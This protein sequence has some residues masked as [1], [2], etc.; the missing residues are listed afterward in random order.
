MEISFSKI[1]RT[2]GS[3]L[4]FIYLNKVWIGAI[5]AHFSTVA[6]VA[7]LIEGEFDKDFY[8]T[9]REYACDLC[10]VI[11][12][13]DVIY[14]IYKVSEIEFGSNIVDHD[15]FPVT[16]KEFKELS[17]MIS[18]QHGAH[19]SARSKISEHAVRD[20]FSNNGYIVEMSTPDQDHKKIDLICYN[21][22][23][24]LPTQVKSGNISLQEIVGCLEAMRV[25][26]RVLDLSN[27]GR[28]I[29]YTFSAKTFPKK[30][31]IEKIHLENKFKCK[32][33]FILQEEI[34]EVEKKYKQSLKD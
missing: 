25:E 5:H 18:R 32:I 30:M 3:D 14:T 2:S 9:V 34:V 6:T 7:I 10:G 8:E 1:T 11:G 31:N 29:I 24:V 22:K 33:L 26:G 28:E 4:Y 17:K 23:H 12:V 21:D 20:Y 15:E 13:E 16:R 19:Q 27:Q